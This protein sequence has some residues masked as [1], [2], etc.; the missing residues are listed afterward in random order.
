MAGRNFKKNGLLSSL[1]YSTIGKVLSFVESRGR[2]TGVRFPISALLI[3]LIPMRPFIT[4][5]RILVLLV[6]PC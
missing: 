6:Q 1:S 4:D 3:C 2:N 5:P